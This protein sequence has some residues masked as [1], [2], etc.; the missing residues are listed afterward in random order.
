MLLNAWIASHLG[1][2]DFGVLAYG[3]AFLV[4]FAAFA[5]LGLQ[6]V[7]M[8][9]FVTSSGGQEILSNGLMLRLVG[10]LVAISV[11]LAS[12]ALVTPNRLGLLVTVALALGIGAQAWDVLEYR[13]QAGGDFRTP[14]L[15]RCIAFALCAL[16]KVALIFSDAGVLYFA[17]ILT[18]EL[19][20]SAVLFAFKT[21]YDGIFV[22]MRFVRVGACTALLRQ[23]IPLIA[24]SIFTALYLRFDHLILGAFCGSGSVGLFSAA[25]RL[26]EAWYVIPT[27]LIAA[28]TPSLTKLYVESQKDFE[29]R[30]VLL[31]RGV[32]FSAV[33]FCLLI[34]IFASPVIHVLYGESF[35]GAV[36][37]LEIHVWTNVFVA[38]GATSGIW[39]VNN[40]LLWPMFAQTGVAAFFSVVSV[41]LFVPRFGI[42]AAALIAVASNAISGC[43]LNLAI[44]SARP[45]FFLQLRAIVPK[46]VLR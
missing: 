44:P 9:E 35:N 42:T 40:R 28:A 1:V 34:S 25:V 38:I 17:A 15:L 23:S 10:A 33:C 36:R 3:Q 30:L 22:R 11:S 27:A 45:V 8:R 46:F 2:A 43:L 19:L 12:F 21:N 13:Y 26:S 20:L 7:L 41:S 39:F 5:A 32:V 31:M 6:P 37:A 18:L 29:D 4:P 16:L 14:I 24:A